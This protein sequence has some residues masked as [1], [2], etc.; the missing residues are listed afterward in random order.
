MLSFE[1][2]AL[3]HLLSISTVSL[4]YSIFSLIPFGFI[5]ASSVV[6]IHFSVTEKV[7]YSIYNKY[8]VN[9]YLSRFCFR[10]QIC[11]VTS[12]W[13]HA[14]NSADLC[15]HSSCHCIQVYR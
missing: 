14:E 2:F 3:C 12:Q 5:C 11:S 9:P 1:V 8:E 10:C 4:L 7:S 6:K 15:L 13:A